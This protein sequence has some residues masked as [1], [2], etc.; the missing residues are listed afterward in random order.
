MPWLCTGGRD[1]ND[2][3]RKVNVS[4]LDFEGEIYE[5]L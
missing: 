3:G 1:T 4:I 2:S 5:N